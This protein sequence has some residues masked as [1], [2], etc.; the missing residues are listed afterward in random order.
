MGSLR[1]KP[2][3]RFAPVY[4]MLRSMIRQGYGPHGPTEL[5]AA[6]RGV[7]T[8]NTFIGPLPNDRVLEYQPDILVHP[9][10]EESLCMSIAEAQLA[11]VAAMGIIDSG[12]VPDY[13]RARRLADIHSMTSLT[14]A[15]IELAE[16]AATRSSL[17]CPGANLAQKRHVPI[18]LITATES[19]LNVAA[20][21]SRTKCNWND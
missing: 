8:R 11:E 4:L 21:D 16:N 17:A 7:A 2:L 15:M 1:S 5:W 3:Y 19:L 12:G 14:G 9:S 13:N 18:R 20:H 6:E 10:L